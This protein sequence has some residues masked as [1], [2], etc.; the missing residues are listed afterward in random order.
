MV[1][2]I[3]KMIVYYKVPFLFLFLLS[4]DIYNL[5]FTQ[6]LDIFMNVETQKN[7]FETRSMFI[8]LSILLFQIF[9]RCNIFFSIKSSIFMFNNIKHDT[10]NYQLFL[11]QRVRLHHQ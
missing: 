1:L 8:C 11:I 2:V 6:Y 5:V 9:R 4:I 7:W 3:S 10:R